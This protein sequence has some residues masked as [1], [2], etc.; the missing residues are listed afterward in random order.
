MS[1]S[2]PIRNVEECSSCILCQVYQRKAILTGSVK[3]DAVSSSSRSNEQQT[4]EVSS[5]QNPV[6]V[7][8]VTV[9]SQYV[10]QEPHCLPLIDV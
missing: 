8:P 7:P 6:A 5:L 2:V 1:A 9:H 4:F 10:I 3:A